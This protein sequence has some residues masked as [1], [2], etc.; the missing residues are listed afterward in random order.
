ML[1]APGASQENN[2]A[3]CSR[4]QGATSSHETQTSI[5][6]IEKLWLVL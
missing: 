5:C 6:N 2:A 3:I 1:A 4:L